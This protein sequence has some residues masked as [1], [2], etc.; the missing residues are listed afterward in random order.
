MGLVSWLF[1]KPADR[2]AKAKKLMAQNRFAEARLEI[3]D[4]DDDEAREVKIEAERALVRV[5][6]ERAQQYARARDGR[7]MESC[8]ALAKQFTDGSQE[9]LFERTIELIQSLTQERAVVEMWSALASAAERRRRLGTDPGDFTLQAYEG[10]CAV[11]LFFGRET[12]FNLPG[13][14]VGPD[15]TWFKPAWVTAAAEPDAPTVVEL[16]AARTAL[17]GAYPALY[18]EGID[19]AGD[20]LARA[21]LSMAAERPERAVEG[22]MTLPVDN[23]PGRFELGRAA[24]A[25]GDHQA[26]AYALKQ[27]GEADGKDVVVGDLSFRALYAATLRW[28]GVAKPAYDHAAALR[29][30]SP[31]AIPHL[32]AALAIETGHFDAARATV[33]GLA[34]DNPSRLQLAGVLRLQSALK[35]QL[36]AHPIIRDDAQRNS[37]EWT[38]AVEAIADVLQVELDAVM[39]SVHAAEADEEADKGAAEAEKKD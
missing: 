30:H 2:I 36:D 21:V 38:A 1:P 19:A 18:H 12:A 25:L 8:L 6:L 34:E 14:E 26:S 31:D 7:Q 9:E 10:T 23:L 35:E 4:V 37:P 11:R 17:K 16:A 28:A 15:R 29:E 33:E 24:G 22:L 3:V 32:F 13:L 5:N 39:A 27:F 20:I